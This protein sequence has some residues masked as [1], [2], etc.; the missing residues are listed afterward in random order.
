MTGVI[1]NIFVSACVLYSGGYAPPLVCFLVFCR[2]SEE[3][4]DNSAVCYGINQTGATAR[5]NTRYYEFFVSITRVALHTCMPI[6]TTACGGEEH[7]GNANVA[8]CR[9]CRGFSF[10]WHTAISGRHKFEAKSQQYVVPA[11]LIFATLPKYV[12]NT[13]SV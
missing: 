6:H 12:V 2:T 8:D 13:A 7:A 11:F 3:A 5:R 9:T 1:V 10:E 4:P